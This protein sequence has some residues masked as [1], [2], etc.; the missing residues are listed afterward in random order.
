MLLFWLDVLSFISFISP[1]L[2]L[3]FVW[4]HYALVLF[5]SR[6]GSCWIANG[7][8]RKC[9][10][11]EG[12]I[13]SIMILQCLK[14]KTVN[15]FQ[16]TQTVWWHGILY[17][18]YITLSSPSLHIGLSCQCLAVMWQVYLK[19]T[20]WKLK[21]TKCMNSYKFNAGS[22]LSGEFEGILWHLLYHRLD[23]V[24]VSLF[25]IIWIACFR[26]VLVVFY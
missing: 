21:V 19:L 3:S 16:Y 15:A 13:F 9:V 2:N 26:L 8:C 24:T 18:V 1:W 23:F 6:Q 7:I 4:T 25:W 14:A 20:H 11:R 10:T 22:G 12:D 17:R 5:A